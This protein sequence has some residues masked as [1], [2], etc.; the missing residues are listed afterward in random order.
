MTEPIQSILVAGYGVMGK[1]VAASF[2]AAGFDVTVLTRDPA[3]ALQDA[4]AGLKAVGAL[5]DAPPDYVSENYPEA[6]PPKQALYR[7]MEAKWGAGPIVATNTSGH[8]LVELA[9]PL[10][11]KSTFIGAHYLQPAD[12]FACVEAIRIPETSDETVARVRA[13]LER[14]DKEV[15]LLNRPIVGAMFNRL[16][17]A[18][19]NEAYWMIQEGYC[20]V[21]DVDTF[22]RLAFGPRM[23]AGGLIEVKDL[24]GLAVHAASQAEIV[25][26]L[27]HTRTP[28][29]FVQN[30]PKEGHTGADAGRGFYDWTGR[31][32]AKRRQEVKDM[33]RKILDIVEPEARRRG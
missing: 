12:A 29:P 1:G 8:D 11:D 24:G 10:A 19:L 18:M 3:K 30:L 31:D 6:I 22:A 23:C 2:L 33:T 15:V 28:A 32:V 25:P 26:Q 9:A 16:Q 4:P 13:A 21:E 20:T 14:T 7:E 17:H 27:T 5:P